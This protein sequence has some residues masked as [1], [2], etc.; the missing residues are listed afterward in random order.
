[1]KKNAILLVAAV[2]TANALQAQSPDNTYTYELGEFKVYMLSEGQQN[3]R[4]NTLVGATP[5]QLAECAPDGNIPMAT[6]AFLLYKWGQLTLVDAGFGTKLFDNLKSLDVAPDQ[7]SVI[8][9]THLHGDHIGG[10][11]RDGKVVF[12]HAEVYLSQPEYDYWTSDEA[13]NALP[14]NRRGGFENA[15]KVIAAYSDKLHL[16]TPGTIDGATTEE[17]IPGVYAVAAYGHTPGHTMYMLQSAAEDRL[18]IWADLTHAMAVQMPYP[19]VAVT[20][21]GTPEQAVASR[22]EVLAYVAAHHIPV[23]GSHIAYPG[24][25]WIVANSKGGY[26]FTPFE[27]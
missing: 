9:L 8:A 25:G 7:I 14:E 11:L 2:C 1:M 19:D 26:T 23:A 27:N 22:K 21:D 12:P 16:F 13:M 24:M 5:E 18:L 15:R 17:I 6:N 4:T 10:M 3:G 20:Y